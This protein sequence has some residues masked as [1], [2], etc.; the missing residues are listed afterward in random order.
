MGWASGSYLAQDLYD[1]IRRYIQPGARKR[2]AKTIVQ[3]FEDHDADDW[4][5]GSKLH[6]DAGMYK[7]CGC[8]F[9]LE[10]ECEDE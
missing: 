4:D 2:V 1:E 7:R 6:R 9:N 8:D 10:C 3:T 5:L